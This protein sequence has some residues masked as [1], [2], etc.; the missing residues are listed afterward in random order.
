ME[1]T[2]PSNNCTKPFSLFG[3]CLYH[4][5][6]IKSRKKFSKATKYRFTTS[7]TSAFL[8]IEKSLFSSK[9]WTTS[10]FIILPIV[11]T[12]FFIVFLW[13]FI[14]EFKFLSAFILIVAHIFL[15]EKPFINNYNN[16]FYEKCIF[17]NFFKIF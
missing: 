16:I 4:H 8:R 10:T 1:D 9:C 2:T 12:C 3:P 6:W 14:A 7:S 17:K 5:P 13:F 11:I 15:K